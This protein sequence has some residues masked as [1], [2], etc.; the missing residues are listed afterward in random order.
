[1]TAEQLQILGALLFYAGLRLFICGV[2]SFHI[3]RRQPEETGGGIKP[4]TR[5]IKP[6]TPATPPPPPSTRMPA[7]EVNPPRI[8]TKRTR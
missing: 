6:I 2:E 5:E 4:I 1:M 7:D 8:P 3:F